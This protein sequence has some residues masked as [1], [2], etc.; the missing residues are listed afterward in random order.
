LLYLAIFQP[1]QRVAASL[2]VAT[3]T[4][5]GGRDLEEVIVRVRRYVSE[6]EHPRNRPTPIQGW[7]RFKPQSTGLCAFLTKGHLLSASLIGGEVREVC[8]GEP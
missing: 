5:D 2:S 1:A 3:D 8:T 7:S 4:G 6:C